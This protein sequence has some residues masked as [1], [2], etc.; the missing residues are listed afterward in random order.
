MDYNIGDMVVRHLNNRFYW[1]M[2]G[3]VK[4]KR[5]VGNRTYYNILWANPKHNTFNSDRWQANEFELVET[6][7]KVKQNT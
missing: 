7:K 1:D 2:V 3:I 6:A 4:S 5:A